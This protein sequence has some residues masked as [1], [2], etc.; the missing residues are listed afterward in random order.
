MSLGKTLF[1]PLALY[2]GALMSGGRFNGGWGGV[3]AM[4]CSIRLGGV[5]HMG[6]RRLYFFGFYNTVKTLLK[7]EYTKGLVAMEQIKLKCDCP[8]LCQLFV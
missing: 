6:R 7:V 5:H 8:F 1:L 2:P 4:D 3:T